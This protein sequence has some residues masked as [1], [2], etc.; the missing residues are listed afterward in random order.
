MKKLIVVTLALVMVGCAFAGTGTGNPN[1]P[2]ASHGEPISKMFAMMEQICKKIETCHP[3]ALADVCKNAIPD[4]TEFAPKLG[5]Y[6]T[7]APKLGDLLINDYT[8]ARPADPAGVDACRTQV[9]ALTCADSAMQNAYDDS[10]ANP[11]ALA[12]EMLGTDC[13]RVFDP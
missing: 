10:E 12:A 11:F 3:E 13:T 6:E 8:G 2:N 4:M 9:E 1:S 7:P 5:A